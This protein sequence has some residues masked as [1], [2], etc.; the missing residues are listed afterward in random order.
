MAARIL[1]ADDSASVRSVIREFL[2]DVE[3]VEV[4]GEAVDGLDAIEQAK[5]LKPD[6]VLLDLSM[7]QMN[8]AE[9]ASILKKT[10]PDVLI[11]LF[12]MYSENVGRALTSALGVNAVLSKPDGMRQLVTCVKAMLSYTDN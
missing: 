11:I 4:C 9:V 5:K 3:E 12:T 8:G 7:P 10:A 2:K 1:I 6:L